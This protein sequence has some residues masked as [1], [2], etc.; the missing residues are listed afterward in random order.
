MHFRLGLMNGKSKLSQIFCSVTDDSLLQT[1]IIE[2]DLSRLEN[3]IRS[4]S[5]HCTLVENVTDYGYRIS[6]NIM[7]TKMMLITFKSQKNI[8]TLEL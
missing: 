6:L 5:R 8:L 2:L 7:P 4:F 3:Q 1:I